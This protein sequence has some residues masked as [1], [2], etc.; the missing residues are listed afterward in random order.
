M[1]PEIRMGPL[2]STTAMSIDTVT[3]DTVYRAEHSRR[4][5]LF[6]KLISRVVD[7]ERTFTVLGHLEVSGAARLEPFLLWLKPRGVR[8]QLSFAYMKGSL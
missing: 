5:A 4:S 1:F 3:L 2:S 7:G 8:V 6:S